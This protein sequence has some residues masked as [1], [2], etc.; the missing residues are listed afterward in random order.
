MSIS[1]GNLKSTNPKSLVSENTKKTASGKLKD[2]CPSGRTFSRLEVLKVWFCRLFFFKLRKELLKNSKDVA[3][4]IEGQ[5]HCLFWLY[6]AQA[7]HLL[8]NCLICGK[9][10][11]MRLTKK[12]CNISSFTE[13]AFISA[14]K[15]PTQK[16][17]HK[18]MTQTVR[19]WGWLLGSL[20]LK[21]KLKPPQTASRISS[22]FWRSTFKPT[23]QRRREGWESWWKKM[24]LLQVLHQQSGH[25]T[26]HHCRV[27]IKNHDGIRFSTPQQKQCYLSHTHWYFGLLWR[28]TDS[29]GLLWL[30]KQFLFSRQMRMDFLF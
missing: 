30:I 23:L 11:L 1:D 15:S 25:Q 21:L 10:L 24:F 26:D 19:V 12:P 2:S 18:L 27:K 9:L 8:C 13:K 4:H 28:V 7:K 20:Q 3:S 16:N 6:C 17:P 5:L 29:L 14:F 22:R